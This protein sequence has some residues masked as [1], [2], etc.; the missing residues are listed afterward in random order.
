MREVRYDVAIDFQGLMKSAVLAR[1]SGARRVI[2]FSIWHLPRKG[3]RPFYSE[4]HRERHRPA[5]GSVIRQNLALLRQLGRHRTC[6][7]ISARGR[8]SRALKTIYSVLG[9]RIPFRTDQPGRRLAE[10][11]LA[12][13][14]IRRDRRVPAGRARLAIVRALGSGEKDS[15]ARSWRPRR[16]R[17]RRA[18]DGSR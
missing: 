11:A 1:A 2:G 7:S 6:D 18:A 17:S 13:G 10:Q 15:P 5:S 14:T 3:A 12:A 16:S 9:G 8:Q 4:I